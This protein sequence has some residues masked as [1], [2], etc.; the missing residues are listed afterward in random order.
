MEGIG[1]LMDESAR[2]SPPHLRSHPVA[3]RRQG[4]QVGGVHD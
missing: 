1:G 2:T 3:M 4:V